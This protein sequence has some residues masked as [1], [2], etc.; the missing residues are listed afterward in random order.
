MDVSRLHGDKFGKKY[1]M[2]SCRRP[3]L[4][5]AVFFFVSLNMITYAIYTISMFKMDKIWSLVRKFVKIVAS[6]C[7]MLRLKCTAF[8]F[9][10]GSA[11]D[12]AGVAYAAPP[13]PLALFNEAY[14]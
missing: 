8:D 4:V 10:W 5:A 14:L 3:R 2:F 12:P 11:P 1:F 6:S 7:Q 9:G 13:D